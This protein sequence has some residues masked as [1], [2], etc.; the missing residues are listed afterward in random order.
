LHNRDLVLVACAQGVP[1]G[2]AT[3]ARFGDLP[4]DSLEPSARAVVTRLDLGEADLG[5]VYATDVAARPGLVQ[6]WPHDPA[7]PCVA[8]AAAALTDR[9]RSFLAFLDTPAARDVLAGHG[10]VTEPPS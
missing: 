7:C 4:V 2:D 10:F 3:W 6:A 8:Y 9:G 1:C 5:I